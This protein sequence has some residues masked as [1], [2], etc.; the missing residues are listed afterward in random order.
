MLLSCLFLVDVGS[1]NIFRESSY[2]QISEGD[3]NTVYIQLRDMSVNTAQEGYKPA[4]RRFVPAAGATLKVYIDNSLDSGKLVTKNAT[5]PYANDPSIWSFVIQATDAING[6]KN[7]R[8]ELNESGKVTR[9]L[10]Q[11]GIRAQS[12][13]SSGV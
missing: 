5:Q 11:G 10:V 12:I 2:C 8:L 7:V 9:G 13:T 1:V 3:T 6:T 4:G